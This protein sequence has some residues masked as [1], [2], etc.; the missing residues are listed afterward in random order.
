MTTLIAKDALSFVGS[1]LLG[2]PFGKFPN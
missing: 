1:S 2:W